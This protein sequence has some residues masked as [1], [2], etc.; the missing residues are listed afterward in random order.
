[1][2][3]NEDILRRDTVQLIK[4]IDAQIEEVTHHA[5]IAGLAR[6][7]LRDANGNWVMS[8]LLVAKAQAYGTLVQ[9]QIKK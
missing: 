1:M 3:I 5:A 6:H 4:E 8:P 2:I 7:K 9:L